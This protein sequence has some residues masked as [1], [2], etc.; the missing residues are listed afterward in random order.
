MS[1]QTVLEDL[2]AKRRSRQREDY[3]E[4]KID[5][6]TCLEYNNPLKDTDLRQRKIWEYIM[7]H[8]LS[9]TIHTEYDFRTNL[10]GRDTEIYGTT[11]TRELCENDAKVTWLYEQIY[12]CNKR[13]KR[14]IMGWIFSDGKAYPSVGNK[15]SRCHAMAQEELDLD[16]SKGVYVEFGHELDDDQKQW[17]AFHIAEL[18]NHDDGEAPEPETGGDI[19][20]QL[21]VAYDLYVKHGIIKDNMTDD[22]KIEWASQWIIDHKPTFVGDN[23][24]STRTDMARRA[25]SQD[26]KDPIPLPDNNRVNQQW[27]GFFPNEDFDPNS[28]DDE[29]QMLI[30]KGHQKQTWRLSLLSRFH[31]RTEFSKARDYYWLVVRCGEGQKDVTSL[32]SL[33]KM[34]QTALTNMTAWNNNENVKEC[35]MPLIERLMFVKQLKGSSADE[36]VAYQWSKKNRKFVQV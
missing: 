27:T 10:G 3:Y 5:R 20:G 34:R 28:Q 19:V 35:G 4:S 17:H 18:S 9:V 25:F 21:S 32:S 29:V 33:K 1:E 16:K 2:E 30:I 36:Y 11:Q 14:A 24:K 13:Q 7:F 12:T 8:N 26:R 31:E 15:R 22:E 23:M 6:L